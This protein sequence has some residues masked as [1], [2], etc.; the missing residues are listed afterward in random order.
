MNGQ[1]DTTTR[2]VIGRKYAQKQKGI[3]RKSRRVVRDGRKAKTKRII[4][5]KTQKKGERQGAHRVGCV[6]GVHVHAAYQNPT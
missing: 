5:K 2:G 6:D 1:S 3:Y 4:Q